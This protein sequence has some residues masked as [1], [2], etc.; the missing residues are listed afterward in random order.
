MSALECQPGESRQPVAA[1]DTIRNLH[2]TEGSPGDWFAGGSDIRSEK[3]E[4]PLTA[5][6]Q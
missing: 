4:H 5:I 6:P 3:G 2:H 1:R